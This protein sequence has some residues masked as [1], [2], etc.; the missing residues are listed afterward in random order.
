MP[1]IP[2]FCSRLMLGLHAHICMMLL[3]MPC[4]DLCVYMFISMLYGQILVFTCLYAWI[5]V[6][7]CLC[8]KFLYV[9][10]H[11]CLDLC[12]LHVSCYFP[13]ACTLYAM[14]TCLDLGYVCH[15]MCYCSHFVTLSFFLV[16]WSIGSD[17][18]QTLWSLSSSIYQGPY[19]RV[20]IILFSCLCLL[21]SML[22]TCVS[23]SSSRLCHTLSE[24]VF[25]WLHLTSIRPCLDVTIWEAL[26]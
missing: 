9:Y 12:F 1:C 7:P 4:L 10:M 20:W 16:F 6:L 11:V 24:I 13:C 23:L 22:Y 17:S 14:F 2:M 21:A 26:P 18:I 8:A 5:Y 3:A 15:V 25:V 19:K